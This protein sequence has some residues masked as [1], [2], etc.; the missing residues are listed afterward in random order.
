MCLEG[1]HVYVC[2][3][4]C[5]CLCVCK[6]NDWIWV[7]GSINQF[8]N[9]L[10]TFG[11]FAC[12]RVFMCVSATLLSNAVASTYTLWA[13]CTRVLVRVCLNVQLCSSFLY[14]HREEHR[15]TFIYMHVSCMLPTWP[16]SDSQGSVLGMITMQRQWSMCV[17]LCAWAEYSLS[18]AH[19]C[20]HG[21]AGTHARKH[22]NVKLPGTIRQD[23]VEWTKAWWIWKITEA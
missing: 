19:K 10:A 15:T 11:P 4:V 7:T 12:V 23:K 21:N 5:L 8:S 2:V 6:I 9:S 16:T 17:C 14:L 18:G 1:A 3:C 20:T 22:T 13:R